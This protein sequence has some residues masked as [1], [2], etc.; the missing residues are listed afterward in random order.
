[1]TALLSPANAPFA[2]SLDWLSGVFPVEA[3]GMVAGRPWYFRGQGCRWEFV[4]SLAARQAP[5]DLALRFD[6]AT[7]FRL[8]GAENDVGYQ[9]E[10]RIQQIIAWAAHQFPGADAT[11]ELVLCCATC[12]AAAT[13]TEWLAG[14]GIRRVFALPALPAD[15]ALA[16]CP[17]Q[18]HYRAA[19]DSEALVLAGRDRLGD[20]DEAPL[21]RHA[22][23]VWFTRGTDATTYRHVIDLVTQMAPGVAPR[24]LSS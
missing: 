19:D 17:A 21:P 11:G 20:T 6:A 1:M 18:Y 16:G 5:I 15:G 2:Y 3:D 12:P 24:A 14:H 7:G 8:H 23:R 22:A 13:L 10:E 4:V 9:S